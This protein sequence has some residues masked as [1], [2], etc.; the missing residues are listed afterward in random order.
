MDKSIN[1]VRQKPNGLEKNK[2]DPY[3]TPDTKV[4]PTQI[5]RAKYGEKF[6]HNIWK[7]KKKLGIVEILLNKIKGKKKTSKYK[8]VK[9]GAT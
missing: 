4:N 3:L 2:L 7:L 9:D 1:R 5:K 6:K 8:E